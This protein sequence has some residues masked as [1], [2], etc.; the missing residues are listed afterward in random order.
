MS[1]IEAFQ[2]G[3]I[4]IDS[5]HFSLAQSKDHYFPSIS[6]KIMP[7]LDINE[8]SN[9]LNVFSFNQLL[10]L[11]VIL[12]EWDRYADVDCFIDDH[13][14]CGKDHRHLFKFGY[15]VDAILIE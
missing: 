4:E 15:W 10:D 2:E 3:E 9:V 6:T 1:L 14:P 8:I 11:F 7:I 13:Y 12:Y 5:I